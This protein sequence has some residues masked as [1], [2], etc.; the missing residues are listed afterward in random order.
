MGVTFLLWLT[1]L[2]LT[3]NTASVGNLIFISPFLSLVFIH[4]VLGERILISSAAG[5]LL[6]VAG[7][8]V[9]RFNR[10][11]KRTG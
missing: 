10:K 5:L 3:D 6:I 8:L 9:Q 2:K 4:Y 11:P 1:A 7:L